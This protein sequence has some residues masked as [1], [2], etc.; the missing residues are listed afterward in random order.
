M[1]VSG[2][3]VKGLG[4]GASSSRPLQHHLEK[5]MN[6]YSMQNNCILCCFQKFWFIILTINLSV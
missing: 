6:R 1:G 3:V 4:L 2:V 5:S